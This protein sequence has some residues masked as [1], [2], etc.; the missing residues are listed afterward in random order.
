MDA[1]VRGYVFGLVYNL[2]WLAGWLAGWHGWRMVIITGVGW[3]CRRLL[4][5]YTRWYL[6]RIAVFAHIMYLGQMLAMHAM[7]C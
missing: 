5:T 1:R 6:L 3:G 2:V 4:L 7:V